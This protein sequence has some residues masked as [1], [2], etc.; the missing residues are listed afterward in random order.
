MTEYRFLQFYADPTPA[1]KALPT[2][3]RVGAESREQ[4]IQKFAR[5]FGLIVDSDDGDTVWFVR[6]EDGVA[7]QYM[8]SEGI[9]LDAVS[10][11]H[12]NTR[13]DVKDIGSEPSKSLTDSGYLEHLEEEAVWSLHTPIGQSVFSR[14]T[15]PVL[16]TQY[17]SCTFLNCR[18]LMQ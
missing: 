12:G 8:V 1:E 5:K 17:M 16:K 7:C 3:V 13:A 6:Q 18:H 4:A 14:R 11:L 15:N 9:F 10:P 2:F